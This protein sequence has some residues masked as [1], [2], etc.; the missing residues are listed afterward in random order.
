MGRSKLLDRGEEV[1]ELYPQEWVTNRRGERMQL[2][3]ATPIVR[4]CTVAEDR[5]AT[6]ELPGQ[7][8]NKAVRV[9]VRSAPNVGSWAGAFFRGEEWDIS[10][11][12]H[13]S[14]GTSKAMR[15]VEFLLR[16]RNGL[17][18]GTTG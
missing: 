2:P 1:I 9:H 16:S 17:G 13:I 12:P 10:Q 4:R 6:A 14:T 5:Q 11:P 8:E 15:H 18:G 7:V 3:S